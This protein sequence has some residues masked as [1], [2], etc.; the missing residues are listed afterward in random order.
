MPPNNRPVNRFPSDIHLSHSGRYC[1]WVQN[2]RLNHAL[3]VAPVA[4]PD[5]V[6]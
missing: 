1:A 4:R 3:T 6:T 2:D 5:D